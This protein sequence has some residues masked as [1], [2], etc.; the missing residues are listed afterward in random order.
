MRRQSSQIIGKRIDM[1]NVPDTELFSAY[2]DGELTAD[3]QVRVEQ[4]L[5]ASPEA[6]LLLEELHPGQH[7]A[8]TAAGETG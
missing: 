5:A 1:N 8:R 3:E 4:I 6:R 7:V 2:L